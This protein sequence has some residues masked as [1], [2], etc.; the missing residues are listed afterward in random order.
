MKSAFKSFDFFR[1]TNPD[2]VKS[3]RTGGL[4]SICSVIVSEIIKDLTN[5]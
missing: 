5:V 1:K 2:H 3:T 4:V